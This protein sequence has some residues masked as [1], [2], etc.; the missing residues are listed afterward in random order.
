MAATSGHSATA[1]QEAAAAVAREDVACDEW[2]WGDGDAWCAEARAAMRLWVQE[3]KREL[4]F[5]GQRQ[6]E[7]AAAQCSCTQYCVERKLAGPEKGC[8]NSCGL[9]YE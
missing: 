2:P 8:V 1:T 7:Q 3:H 9:A 6:L 4:G 5:S